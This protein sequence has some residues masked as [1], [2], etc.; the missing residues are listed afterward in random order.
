[1]LG[2]CCGQGQQD[3][4]ALRL[5][6]HRAAISAIIHRCSGD[7]IASLYQ[8]GGGPVAGGQCQWVVMVVEK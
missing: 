2:R 5:S 8:H 3:E 1:M 4:Q 7:V 6:K